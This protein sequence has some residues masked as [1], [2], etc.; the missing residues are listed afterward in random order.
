MYSAFADPFVNPTVCR[1]KL[2]QIL[3]DER[4]T[5]VYVVGLALDYC[6]KYTAIDSAKEGF[7]TFVV[8]EGCKAVDPG[9]LSAVQ[10]ELESK[11]VAVVGQSSE[12]VAKVARLS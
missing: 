2:A 10:A 9:S 3:R 6:V 8:K 12:E 11:V 7:T 4:I 1:S 5:H